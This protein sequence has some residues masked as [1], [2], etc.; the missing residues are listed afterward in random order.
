MDIFLPALSGICLASAFL[1]FGLGTAAY[2]KNP[3]SSVNRLFFITM[4]SATYWAFCEFMIWQAGSADAVW[5]WLK[6]SSF[7]PFVVAFTLHFVIA[8]TNQS[9]YNRHRAATLAS[10]Y[11]PAGVISA[12]LLFTD[13]IFGIVSLPGGGFAYLPDRMSPAYQLEAVYILIVMLAAAWVV[14]TYWQHAET[15]KVRNQARLICVAIATV[16]FF[17]FL[18]GILLPAFSIYTPNLVFIGIVIFSFVI[19]IAIRKHELFVLSPRTAVPEILKTMPDAMVLAD[20]NGTI[21]SA[22][23]STGSIFNISTKSLQG[24]SLDSCFLTDATAQIRETILGEG[25]ITDFETTPACTESRT[26]S[27]A[28]TL[29]RDPA[30]EPAGMVLIIRDI[31]E[32][33]ATLEALRI[34]GRKISLLTQV[35]RHDINN[36]ISALSGYLLLLKE[37][38]DDPARE[39]YVSACMEIAEKIHNQLQFTREY[40]EIGAKKPDWT[41]LE[42]VFSQVLSE[43]QTGAVVIRVDPLHAEVFSD[44]MIV[45]VFYNIIENSLRHGGTVSQV[46]VSAEPEKDGTLQI[47]IMDDGVGIPADDKEQIFRYGFGNNTGLGLAVSRDILSLTG[48]TITETGE[49]GNGARF[50]IVVPQYSWRRIS[51]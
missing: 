45:K 40:Q 1:T 8:F 22:N 20:T 2:V 7:W 15:A 10:I 14:Y 17:G 44:P 31:T 13:W 26:V 23:E 51:G 16:I 39:S 36:L 3:E 48:I 25:M 28:G 5:F 21:I 4:L 19:T 30:G 11:I 18:S 27:V 43:L 41:D 38:P 29:V 33:K 49:P 24:R 9:Y 50:E 42:L 32:R 6:A 37:N 46:H 12:I 47:V 34:A 35:T